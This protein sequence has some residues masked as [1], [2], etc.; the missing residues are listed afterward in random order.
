VFLTK[1]QNIAPYYRLRLEK[2][3]AANTTTICHQCG[4]SNPSS[5]KL[6]NFCGGCGKLINQDLYA[7]AN[8]SSLRPIA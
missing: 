8:L 1:L 2:L 7:A 4:F 5:Q 6:E 3:S